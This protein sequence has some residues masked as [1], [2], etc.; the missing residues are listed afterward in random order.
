MPFFPLLQT[1]FQFYLYTCQDSVHQL[2]R[3]VVSRM[4][5]VNTESE[6]VARGNINMPAAASCVLFNQDEFDDLDCHTV[7]CS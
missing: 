6:F 7:K 1:F 3:S 2:Y 4:M 5:H